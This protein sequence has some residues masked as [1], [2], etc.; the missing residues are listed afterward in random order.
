MHRNPGS[1]ISGKQMFDAV[2]M[3]FGDRVRSIE[4]YW[5]W[6]DN[7]HKVNRLVADGVPLHDAVGQ[8]WTADRAAAYGFTRIFDLNTVP[9][10]ATGTYKKINLLFL[11][12]G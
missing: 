1:P 9:G 11:R 6:G 5:A 8:T 10:A 2:M 3:H 7:L 12:P 4:G